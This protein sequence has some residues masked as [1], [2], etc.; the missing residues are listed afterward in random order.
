MKRI[1][2]A[3][4]LTALGARAEAGVLYQQPPAAC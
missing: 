4:L 2:L 3:A 1:L